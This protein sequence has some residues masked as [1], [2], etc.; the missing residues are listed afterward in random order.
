DKYRI[1]FFDDK[2]IQR[3]ETYATLELATKALAARQTDVERGNLGFVSDKDAPTFRTF[4]TVYLETHVRVHSDYEKWKRT[5]SYRFEKLKSLFGD[6]KLSAIMPNVID[7]YMRDEKDKGRS[8]EGIKRDIRLLKAIL[9]KAVKN[10][11]I[12]ANPI[13]SVKSAARLE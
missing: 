3:S 12:T 7:E 1:R 2:G 8:V 6:Y 5:D 9:N 13:A 4:S 10:G 11:D